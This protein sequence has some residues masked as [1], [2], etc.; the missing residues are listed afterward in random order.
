VIS[1]QTVTISSEDGGFGTGLQNN[2]KFGGREVAMLGDIDDDGTLEMAVGAFTSEGGKGAIWM[3]SL[4]RT[5]FNVESKLK[6]TEGLNGFTDALTLGSNPNGSQGANFGHALCRVGDLNGDGVP[7]LMT[8]AN[9]QNEGWGYILYLNKDK[10]VKTF[11]RLNGTE[12]GFDFDFVAE[13]RFS[14]SI[15]FL[16]D[17]RG[18]GTV[19]VNY[20]GGAGAGSAGA[21]YLLFFKPCEFI[22]H[23][24]L[25]F[26]SGGSNLYTNWSHP[27]QTVSEPLTFEQCTFKAFE[28]NAPH[29]TYNASDGRCICKDSAATLSV[30]TEQSTAYSNGCNSFISTDLNVLDHGIEANVFPNPTNSEVFLEIDQDA[31]DVNDNISLFSLLGNKVYTS[32]KVTKQNKIDLSNYPNGIYF[33]VATINE[34]SKTYKI[35]KE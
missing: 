14:R 1:D 7:E 13:E 28:T 16:G 18:D 24:G 2:D 30:S 3:L 32:Y 6:I 11:T 10:T 23:P 34:K 25:N 15:S 22:K 33:L 5:T 26:W 35:I 12:G 8:G 20:G 21:L 29:I 4:N 27:T 9:Q 31:F 19:A 17:L